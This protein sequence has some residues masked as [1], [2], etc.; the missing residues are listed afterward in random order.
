LGAARDPASR[1]LH[2]VDDVNSV[3]SV[4]WSSEIRLL[5]VPQRSEA[6]S[7]NGT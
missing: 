6:E 7:R 2:F 5:S 1:F 4:D 3:D